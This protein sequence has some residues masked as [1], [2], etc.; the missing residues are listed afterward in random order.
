MNTRL[1]KE[2]I[3]NTIKSPRV[4]IFMAHCSTCLGS[5]SRENPRLLDARSEHWAGC[6]LKKDAGILILVGQLGAGGHHHEGHRAPEAL[7]EV[8]L[9]MSPAWSSSVQQFTR[10]MLS[11]LVMTLAWCV[12]SVLIQFINIQVVSWKTGPRCWHWRKTRKC[13]IQVKW[14]LTSGILIWDHLQFYIHALPFCAL[15]SRQS[16]VA[17]FHYRLCFQVILRAGGGG[18]DPPQD[19]TAPGGPCA[20]LTGGPGQEREQ[21]LQHSHHRQ[22]LAEQ[23]KY[24]LWTLFNL[25]SVNIAA[26]TLLAWLQPLLQNSWKGIITVKILVHETL[27]F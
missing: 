8:K 22:V 15:T 19:W 10:D 16:Q 20:D 24:C 1:F 2:S 7:V 26:M 3:L 17:T 21:H 12:V 6:C 25:V 27:A 23:G 14:E 4:R 5:M 18:R 11:L 9:K 13:L